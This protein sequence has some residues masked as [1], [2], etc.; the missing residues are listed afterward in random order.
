MDS[1]STC[2]ST[3]CSMEWA[4]SGPQTNVTTA[5]CVWRHSTSS[6]SILLV[7]LVFFFFQAEDGIRDDLVTGVQTCAL[8]ISCASGSRR[9]G[10]QR[11][12]LGAICRS[13]DE[14]IPADRRPDRRDP[15]AH[16]ACGTRVPRPEIGRASCRERV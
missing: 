2:Y 1:W 7:A 10:L 9:S 3:R 15:D 4:M 14:A 11:R 12:G 6:L 5:P 16:A 13:S 8:P